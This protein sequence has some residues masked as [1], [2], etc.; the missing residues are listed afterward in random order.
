MNARDIVAYI[1]NDMN[2]TYR[3]DDRYVCHGAIL[4]DWQS[5]NSWLPAQIEEMNL[6][7]LQLVYDDSF[8]ADDDSYFHDLCF[9]EEWFFDYISMAENNEEED[10]F[11]SINS[12]WTNNRAEANIRHLNAFVVDYDYYKL[13]EYKDLSA[14]EMWEIIAPALPLQPSF[15]I[16][17]GRGLYAIFCIKH[18]PYDC[19]PLYKQIYKRL[20]DSQKQFG[21]DAKAALTTQVIRIPGS[22]NSR[23][24]QKVELIW[25]Y[26]HRN[27]LQDFAK[28][29]LPYSLEEVKAYKK[30]RKNKTAGKISKK[31]RILPNQIIR[32]EN[33]CKQ[34]ILTRNSKGVLSGYREQLIYAL[35]ERYQKIGIPEKQILK[36]I[37]YFNGL[38]SVPLT[39]HEVENRCQPARP[40]QYVSSRQTLAKKLAITPEE[41]EKMEYLISDK[42]LASRRQKRCRSKKKIMGRTKAQH[43]RFLRRIEALKALQ[44]GLKLKEIAKRLDI[45]IKTLRADFMYIT[46]HPMEFKKV[47]DSLKTVT[48]SVA[49]SIKTIFQA[50]DTDEAVI[51][52]YRC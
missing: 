27:T 3:D 48:F 45:N 15:V 35:W 40:Y 30:Q 11:F 25:S 43:E 28:V 32:F 9:K 22:V 49:E 2:K 17:S 39:E 12:F 20:V 41:A 36:K 42:Q 31:K 8:K 14:S 21:A 7:P 4:K 37:H 44:D 47:L 16:R 6:T 5:F 1:H 29:Y 51:G 38:F 19:V 52:F 34:L 50:E 26:P 24:G 33:D 23:N 46:A 13:D 18:A 10:A